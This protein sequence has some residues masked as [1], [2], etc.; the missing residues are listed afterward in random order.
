MHR[1]SKAD[2]EKNGKLP[3]IS[4][5]F[6]IIEFKTNDVIV[7]SDPLPD[8]KGQDGG[9]EVPIMLARSVG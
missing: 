1:T 9:D 5:E 2:C 3:Y 8:T 7:T 4:P 6:E